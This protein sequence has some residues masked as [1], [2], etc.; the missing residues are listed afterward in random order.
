LSVG[1]LLADNWDEFSD[2]VRLAASDKGFQR[3]VLRHVDETIP[4]DTLKKVAQ[5]AK[6]HCPA[7][8]AGLCKMITR[9]ASQ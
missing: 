9:A 5:N 6:G 2:L 1:R 7:D 4:A 3:F 8:A